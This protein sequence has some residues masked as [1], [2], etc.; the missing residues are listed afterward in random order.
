MK[1]M[2]RTRNEQKTQ[3]MSPDQYCSHLLI[4]QAGPRAQNVLGRCTWD[5]AAVPG[6]LTERWEPRGQHGMV[7]EELTRRADH[8][9]EHE[10]AAHVQQLLSFNASSVVFF[11]RADIPSLASLQKNL[12]VA[13]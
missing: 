2:D 10:T 5:C 6:T 7:A 3:F 1:Q 12:P 9:K 13:Y 4:L 8:S 11:P